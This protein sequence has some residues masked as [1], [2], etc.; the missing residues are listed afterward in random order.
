MSIHTAVPFI[1]NGFA[2]DYQENEK[3]GVVQ[4]QEANIYALK[5]LPLA[6]LSEYGTRVLTMRRWPRG[7]ARKDIDLWVPSAGPSI[8]LL[9]AWRTERMTWEQFLARYVE[10]QVQQEQCRVVCYEQGQPCSEV[11]SCRALD[12]LVQLAQARGTVTLLC[13]E[14]TYCHR[15]I[16]A[17]QVTQILESCSSTREGDLAC[18]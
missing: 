14:A 8:A 3:A 7:I 2:S 10:E 11:L 9:V 16:L 4:V 1:W 17:Q 15:F 5:K 18:H 12:F 13:W 6:E